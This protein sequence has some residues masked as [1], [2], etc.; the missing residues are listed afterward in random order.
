MSSLGGRS[1]E[2]VIF[3]NQHHLGRN[4]NVQDISL[5]IVEVKGSWARFLRHVENL[6]EV[7]TGPLVLG[8]CNAKI[9]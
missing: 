7:G 2:N 9:P 3:N 4:T 1:Y 8:E 5:D 6:I